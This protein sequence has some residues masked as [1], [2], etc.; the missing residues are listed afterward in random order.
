MNTDYAIAA[1]IGCAIC[2][3]VAAILQKVG[4]D[5]VAA[6]TSYSPSVL[7]KLGKQ[8]PYVAGLILDSF[9]GVFTL[10][11]VNRL[12]LF[13]VQA[14]IASSVV[15]TAYMERF[16]LKR[17]LRLRT[18]L[19]SFVV[20]IGL[21]VLAL[22]SHGEP[23]V[24]ASTNVKDVVILLPIIMV[25]IGGLAVKLNGKLSSALLAALSGICFGLVSVAGRQLVYPHPVWLVLKDPLIWALV[26]YG[27]LG[28]FFFTAALQRTLAT[29]T[30][31]IMLSTQTLIPTI[32]G[33]MFLG[34]T[35]RNGLWSLVWTGCVLVASSCVFMAVSG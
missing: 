21:G 3:A 1:A 33:V 29:I 15:L 17:R 11:A 10:I 19:A 16:Y 20:V 35:P 23:A 24:A 14:V 27:I 31:G 30:N 26:A 18:Y 34:D 4:S 32:V 12:P 13:L 28:V 22:A 9:A 25:L 2:N 8:S 6:I 5:K 7:L